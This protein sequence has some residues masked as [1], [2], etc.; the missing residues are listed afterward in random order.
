MPEPPPS[1]KNDFFSAVSRYTGIA[2]ALPVATFVGYLMG[3]GLDHLFGTSFLKV[4][5]LL[6][7]IAAGFIQLIR[8]LGRDSS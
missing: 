5:F 2:L 1:K 4:V 7:G 3:Y 8:E 6:L